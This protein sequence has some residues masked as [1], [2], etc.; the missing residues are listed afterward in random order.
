[1]ENFFVPDFAENFGFLRVID[2][3]N[4]EFV[5]FLT[6][7]P[8]REKILLEFSERVRYNTDDNLIMRVNFVVTLYYTAEGDLQMKR[9]LAV[10]L[11]AALLV[12]TLCACGGATSGSGSAASDETSS[13]SG[14]PH[15][16]SIVVCIAQDL[17]ESLDPY[18]MTAAGTREV[19]F[20]VYEGLVKVSSDGSIKEAVAESYTVSDDQLTYTFKLRK[21]VKFHNG[22]T[23][24]VDDVLHSFDTCAATAI[25]ASLVEALSNVESK[26]AT[27][28]STIVIKLKRPMVEFIRYIAYVYITPKDYKDNKTHPVGTGPFKYVSRSVQENVILEKNADYYGTPAYLDKVTFQ[29][30]EDP[31]VRD[32]ALDS[33]SIDLCNHMTNEEVAALSKKYKV[34]EG[35]MNVA[36]GLYLNNAKKPFDNEKVRQALCYAID[37]DAIMQMLNEGHGAKIGTAMYPALTEYFDESLNDT[38]TVDTE[39]AKSLL[40]EAGYPDGFTFTIRVPSNYARHVQT[41]EIIVEQLK[42]IG[43]TAKIEQV[44]WSTWLDDVYGKRNYEA[45][46]IGFD[47]T[48]PT[49]AAML[50][51]Y[52]SDAPNNMFNYSNKEYDKAYAKADNAKN[53]EEAIG[54]YK[55]CEKILADT[56]ASVYIQDMP[57]FVALKKNLDGYNYYPMY[58]MDLSTVHYTD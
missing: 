32:T 15:D 30:Y 53:A 51:R 29:I 28:D 21:G 58:A 6:I 37:R 1:M 11:A 43:V 14:E 49:A 3:E 35:L 55:D 48:T 57:D 18:K 27:D 50:Q 46:V 17:D 44:D 8:S 16:N 9:I 25:E 2:W 56:A 26:E 42:A 38:Y 45:T 20:N 33:G 13:L 24:T 10:L 41:A 47:A 54:L 34:Q 22:D 52:N 19:L 31:T 4:I 5:N 12:G 23:V 7:C 36:Q 40:A 39:K